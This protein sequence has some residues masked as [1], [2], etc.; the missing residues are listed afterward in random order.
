[1]LT[2]ARESRGMSQ[3]E[4]ARLSGVP[5]GTL[6]KVENGLTELP[7]ERIQAIAD[8][9]NYP[10]ELLDWPDP[11]YGFGSSMYHHRKQQSVGQTALRRIHAVS[12]LLVA[13]LRRLGTGID[14]RAPLRM[15]ALDIDGFG[16]PEEVA[17]AVRAAWLVPM[18]PIENMIAL[19]E[20]AGALVIRRDLG[21][22]RITAISIRPPDTRPLFLLNTGLP[23]DR[24]RFTLAHELGHL[25]MHEIPRPEAEA[26]ADRFAAE[27]L[28]PAAEIRSQ[29]TRIDLAK[30]ALLKQHW[31]TA[32]SALIRRAHDLDVITDARYRSLLSQMAQRG[33]NRV[34]P[35]E[36]PREEP[37]IV[38][39]ILQIH[40][41]THGY[42]SEELARLVGLNANE[43][44]NEFPIQG[45][46]R[47]RLVRQ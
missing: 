27:F 1:M 47:L 23:P 32:M 42:T 24:E 4:L 8:A 33:F 35:V 45:G 37:S 20:A 28:M 18:G 22:P 12:N 34:E 43:F 29:L 5:Q 9:L 7:E 41:G 38:S 25:V 46:S 40:V 14:V 15:P 11:I 26:E 36:L 2:V 13:R 30:A 17:R 10:R 6:S 39:T 16:G 3:T 31:K 44:H 21:T 19:L